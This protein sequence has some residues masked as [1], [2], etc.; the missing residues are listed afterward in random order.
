MARPK[1]LTA[2]IALPTMDAHTTDS[3]VRRLFAQYLLHKSVLRRSRLAPA[4]VALSKKGDALGAALAA[5]RSNKSSS[6]AAAELDPLVD[7]S[8]AAIVLTL[9]GR[10]KATELPSAAEAQAILD[11][12]FP[13]R[14]KF[15]QEKYV[16]QWSIANATLQ[17]LLAK[18]DDGPS[19]AEFLR[20]HGAGDL[21]DEVRRLH[22]KFAVLL[23]VSEGR[24]APTTVEVRGPMDDALEAAR[25]FVAVTLSLSSNEIGEDADSI[26]NDI[27]SVIDEFATR[28][29]GGEKGVEPP[30][31]AT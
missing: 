25:E 31:P 19:A 27:L 7:A 22:D 17:Q 16:R 29:D 1:S 12:V 21:L 9:E 18:R 5:E 4:A 3:F 2:Y 8:W 20:A 6:K 11:R 24:S 30:T 14:L 23:G 13:E 15:T 28:R 10:A 26:K